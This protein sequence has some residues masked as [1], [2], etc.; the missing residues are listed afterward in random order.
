MN[1]KLKFLILIILWAI[2]FYP[3]YP[4]LF[5]TWLNDSNNSHGMLVPLISGYFIWQKK[6]EL[7]SAVISNSNWG[8]V[9]LVISMGLYLVSY[10]G[11]LAFV[12]RSMI[13]FS[14]V[15]LMLFTF[16]SSIF[17]LM[18]FP[19]FFLLFMVP[20]PDS[21]VGFVA[22]PLQ[23]F[24]T[25]VSSIVIQAFSIPVYREGNMLYFVQ[26][27]LET[28]EACSGVRSIISL[29]MLSVIF[30]YLLDGGWI[31]KAILLASAVPLALSINIIRVSGTGI[32]A[33]FHGEKAARG[34]LHE[35]SGIAVFAFGFIALLIEF[36]LLRR[37]GSKVSKQPSCLT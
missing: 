27:Q 31:R 37:I 9:I 12:S 35:F 13:I 8:A 23:L 11:G 20:V 5:Y 14:L 6:G 25:K 32:L 36:L 29:T 1:M 21:I 22:F 19:F 2:A 28:A 7:K 4:G 26:T 15:G 30:V 18:V 16:G 24:A 3:I 34:F 10:A 33:H 17:K